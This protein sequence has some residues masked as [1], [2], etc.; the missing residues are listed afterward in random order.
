MKELD[1][2]FELSV[3]EE[4]QS[5]IICLVPMGFST[6][7]PGMEVG[8]VAAIC[9]ETTQSRSVTF[10]SPD[11]HSLSSRMLRDQYQGNCE[12]NVVAIPWILNASSERVRAVVSGNASREAPILIPERY[13][14]FD[15]VQKIYFETPIGNGCISGMATAEVYIQHQAIIGLVFVYK[16]G[17]RASIGDVNTG[18]RQSIHFP[19]NTCIVG[20]SAAGIEHSI[21]EIEFEVEGNEH[22]APQQLKLSVPLTDAPVGSAMDSWRYVWCRN[23]TSAA[24]FQPHT[25]RDAAYE[26]PAESR[27]VGLCVGCQGF[28]EVG[29]LYEPLYNP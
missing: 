25:L 3:D 6:E 27:L 15:Q 20:F 23:G 24:S 28:L 9:I 12:E 19:Q 2:G 13:P 22:A 10:R 17:A 8:Q 1:D 29:A 18:A 5:I 14:P 26:P 21:T 11:L 4:V 7:S 16:S